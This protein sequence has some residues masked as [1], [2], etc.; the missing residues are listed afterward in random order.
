MQAYANQ[1]LLIFLSS[2]FED[3]LFSRSLYLPVIFLDIYRAT[4]ISLF[5]FFFT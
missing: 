4:E 3:A 1:S 5:A 2:D